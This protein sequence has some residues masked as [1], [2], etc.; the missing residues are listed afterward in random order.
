MTRW[1]KEA[2]YLDSISCEGGW[3]TFRQCDKPENM[4]VDF[5]VTANYTA[6]SGGY[7]TLADKAAR[8]RGDGAREARGPHK[9][10]TAGRDS[11]PRQI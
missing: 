2:L 8:L 7:S 4:A 10:D 3:R 6:G 1:Q 11:R 9:P 5:K